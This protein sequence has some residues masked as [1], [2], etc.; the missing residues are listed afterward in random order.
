MPVSERVTY[1]PRDPSM[2]QTFLL[3]IFLVTF[4]TSFAFA[5]DVVFAPFKAVP[6]RIEET[7]D[8]AE[9]SISLAIYS[10]S[11][12]RL[13]KKVKEAAERGVQVRV[14]LHKARM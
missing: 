8:S 4:I 13:Q 10:F 12:T 14:I 5:V 7:L 6:E 1:F 2:K 3:A 11:D 9:D